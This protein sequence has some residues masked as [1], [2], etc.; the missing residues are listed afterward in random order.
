MIPGFGP[1][2]F[3]SICIAL[4]FRRFGGA[5]AGDILAVKNMG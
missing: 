5:V 3:T 4:G 2:W 1:S